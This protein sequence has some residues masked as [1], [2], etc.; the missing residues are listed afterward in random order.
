VNIAVINESTLLEEAS[1]QLIVDALRTS[2]RVF[3]YDWDLVMPN[4][5]H[6]HRGQEQIELAE[7]HPCIIVLLDDADQAGA[8]G[9]HATTPDGKPYAAVF[10]RD[11]VHDLG[12]VS[13]VPSPVP[14]QMVADYVVQV[15]D[16]EAKEAL[17]DPDAADFV[18][19][20]DGSLWA[21]EAC[22]AVESEVLYVTASATETRCVVSD[23]V[24]PSFFMVGSPGPY[25]R[26]GVLKA[27][28]TLA[29]GGYTI[30]EQGGTVSQRFGDMADG[31]RRAKHE[32]AFTADPTATATASRTGW[33]VV[34]AA[35][36]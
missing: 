17:L 13:A 2:L 7:R 21:K 12:N 5:E 28:F 32:A 1:V 30:V 8:L 26:A 4:V 16:H 23:Y 6:G 19:A 9:Y 27:P 3:S 25:D 31:W 20:G 36:Q 14:V 10:V 34:R 35:I 24:M 11:S 18:D 22:D 15:V 33:R 29:P